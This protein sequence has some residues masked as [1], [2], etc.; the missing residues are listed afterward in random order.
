MTRRRLSTICAGW[1]R[2]H[3]G[4]S[5]IRVSDFIRRSEDMK[6][7]EFEREV[8]REG[9]N[10]DR[11]SG[12]VYVDST[13]GTV[14]SIS[15]DDLFMFDC[16]WSAFVHLN[17]DVQEPLFDLAYQLAKTPP[18]EREEEKRYR[19]RLDV[20]AMSSKQ[21]WSVYYL[22]KHK[23]AKMYRLGSDTASIS[24]QAIFT[25]SEITEMDITGFERIE[26]KDE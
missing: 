18:A 15:T 4:L 11:K 6:Y 1:V 25:E 5:Y 13:T 8:E 26:V 16:D 3:F 7:S 17:R 20:P 21:A 10:V 2:I 22:N 23:E 19:L 9:F 12:T 24:W 14:M